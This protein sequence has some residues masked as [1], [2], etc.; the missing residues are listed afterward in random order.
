MDFDTSS[1]GSDHND[2]DDDEVVTV[3]VGD[4][5]EGSLGTSTADTFIRAAQSLN[6][7]AASALV[8]EEDSVVL[9]RFDL[10]AVAL[11]AEIVDAKLVL[12]IQ[13]ESALVPGTVR[14]CRAAEPWVEGSGDQ[15]TDV[16]NAIESSAGVAWTTS[17]FS[18]GDPQCGGDENLDD[19]EHMSTH[20][21]VDMV[22]QWIDSPADNFGL[23]LDGV[24]SASVSF[25][26][27]ETP[28]TN[29][30]PILLLMIESSS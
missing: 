8:L 30:R 25:F 19:D 20:L 28:E 22:Q 21:D 26:S 7:G 23:V 10:S 24:G 1:H 5:E 18:Y 13:D 14:V 3:R 12:A 29:N 11:D 17:P 2:D 16:A 9:L 15:T 6:W 4:G 27:S